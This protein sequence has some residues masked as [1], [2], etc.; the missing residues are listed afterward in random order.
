MLTI[1]RM[2][3]QYLNVAVWG[4]QCI[5][6]C[7]TF[8]ACEWCVVLT[9]LQCEYGPVWGRLLA[10]C[11]ERLIHTHAS[12]QREGGEKEGESHNLVVDSLAAEGGCLVVDSPPK[13]GGPPS[14]HCFVGSCHLKRLNRGAALSHPAS[15]L[16]AFAKSSCPKTCVRCSQGSACRRISAKYSF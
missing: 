14:L 9:F 15:Y 16:C 6:T 3:C 1:I 13:R 2:Y 10:L 12:E 5:S 8:G 4:A 11:E 7:V